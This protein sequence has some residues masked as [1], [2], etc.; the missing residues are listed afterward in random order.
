MKKSNFIL[1]S[2]AA[3]T[4]VNLKWCC[5]LYLETNSMFLVLLVFT[6]HFCSPP[7]FSTSGVPGR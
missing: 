4:Q 5:F 7:D 6:L 2:D 1:L 3:E